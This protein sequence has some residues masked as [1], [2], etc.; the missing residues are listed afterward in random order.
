M[1]DISVNE[2]QNKILKAVLENNKIINGEKKG[3]TGYSLSKNDPK[4]PIATWNDNYKNLEKKFLIIRTNDVKDTNGR[5]N[6]EFSITPLGIIQLFDKIERKLICSPLKVFN[7]LFIHYMQGKPEEDKL[8]DDKI[9][10]N[11]FHIF[12][13]PDLAEKFEDAFFE[14][15]NSIKI[16]PYDNT[17]DLSYTLPTTGLNVNMSKFYCQ[18]HDKINIIKEDSDDKTSLVRMDAISEKT[19]NYHIA[20]FFLQAFLHNVYKNLEFEIRSLKK[21]KK[22]LGISENAQIKIGTMIYVEEKMLALFT[23]NMLKNI[24]TFQR[25]L[26]NIIK[27]SLQKFKKI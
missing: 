11:L 27:N 20:K 26:D 19:L 12:K 13:Q 4:I 16:K 14:I 1:G 24:K 8:F 22:Q 10:K 3:V 9:L 6:K 5:G 17:I 21:Y 25:E 23:P 7:C 18:S 15:I 2:T